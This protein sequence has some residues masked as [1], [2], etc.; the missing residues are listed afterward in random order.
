MAHRPRYVVLVS[1]SQEHRATVNELYLNWEE[2]VDALCETLKNRAS[3]SDL[4][5]DIKEV[6][7]HNWRTRIPADN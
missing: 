1:L 6:P 3:S 5:I 2:A 7:I 4:H